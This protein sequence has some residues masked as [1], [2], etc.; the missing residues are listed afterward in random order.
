[1]SDIVKT[2]RHGKVLEIVF[3]RP[4][5]NAINTAASRALY[6]AFC[7]NPLFIP[8]WRIMRSLHGFLLR[9][10]RST[11]FAFGPRS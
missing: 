3:D 5:V 6:E 10:R 7:A 4:P 1:M 11:R 9:L 8:A 2:T